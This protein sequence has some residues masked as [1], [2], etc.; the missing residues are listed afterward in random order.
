MITID[1]YMD[2][3]KVEK[4]EDENGKYYAITSRM[5]QVDI[6]DNTRQLNMHEPIEI[7]I[8]CEKF[9]KL[10]RQMEHDAVSI[11]YI[12]PTPK[13]RLSFTDD[14]KGDDDDD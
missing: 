7:Q 8:D 1:L 4:R 5:A 14:E 10:C 6:D 12:Q 9:A 11:P 2:D 3:L 13:N